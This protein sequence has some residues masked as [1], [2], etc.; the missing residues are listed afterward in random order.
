M[1]CEIKIKGG[2]NLIVI[3]VLAP[4]TAAPLHFPFFAFKLP[5]ALSFITFSLFFSDSS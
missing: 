1:R 5:R 3:L 2:K 4:I